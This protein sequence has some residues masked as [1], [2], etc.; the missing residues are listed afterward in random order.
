[1]SVLPFEQPLF[2]FPHPGTLPVSL[3]EVGSVNNR[4][5]G[6]WKGMSTVKSCL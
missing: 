4:E 3:A 1:M 5:W 6:L 2:F